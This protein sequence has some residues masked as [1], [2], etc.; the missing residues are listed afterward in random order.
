MRCIEDYKIESELSLDSL[1]QQIDLLERENAGRKT[2]SSSHLNQLKCL[3][4]NIAAV[5]SL[6]SNLHP[7]PALC[8][9]PHQLLSDAAPAPKTPAQKQSGNKRPWT[10]VTA[11]EDPNSVLDASMFASIIIPGQQPAASSA[12][13]GMPYLT[14]V[15]ILV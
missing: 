14:N 2:F 3:S 15:D 4:P 13:Q 11:E 12:S 1:K 5:A 7:P 6:P 9:L 8:S 10:A